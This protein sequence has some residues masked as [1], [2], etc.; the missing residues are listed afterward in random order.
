[1]RLHADRSGNNQQDADWLNIFSKLSYDPTLQGDVSLPAYVYRVSQL[2]DLY[3]QGFLAQNYRIIIRI[4]IFG[5][6]A[7]SSLHLTIWWWL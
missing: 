3:E 1:M 7:Q 6:L 5:Y 4:L 2:D